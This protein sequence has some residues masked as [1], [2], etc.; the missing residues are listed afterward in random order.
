MLL[1]MPFFSRNR[2]QSAWWL[3]GTLYVWWLSGCAGDP[4]APSTSVV[5]SAMPEESGFERGIVVS[6]AQVW[7]ETGIVLQPGQSVTV[8]AT[9]EIVG[10][11]PRRGEPGVQA[12]V[13]P[14]GT[15]LFSDD[16][17]DREFPLPAA[18][19]GPAPCYGLIARIGDGP[20]FFVGRAHSWIADRGGPLQLGINDFDVSDN[21]GH[22]L[23]NV[24]LTARQHPVLYERVV[25]GREPPGRPAE[26]CSV[27]VFYVDGL[28]PDVVR[29]MAALGHLPNIRRHFLDNGAWL[30]K[31]FTAFPSDTITSNGTM[32]TGCF[33]DR[34]GIKGQVNF[35]RRRL[36]SESFLDPFGPQRSASWLS[37]Q[38][39]DKV[40]QQTQAAAV[41]LVQGAPGREEWLEVRQSSVP[42]LYE[43]LQNAGENW[44]VGVLPVMT[45]VPPPLWSRS[46]TRQMPYFQT[47]RA[48]EY[49]DDANADYAVKNLL[50]RREKVTIVW[51]SETDTCSHKC[52]RGQFGVTRRTIARADGLIGGVVDEL[53]AQGRLDNTYLI[54]VSDHGHVGGRDTHLSH[55]DLASD[56]FFRP[57]QINADGEWVGGGLGLS[58]RMHRYQNRHPDDSS[59]EFVF[60]DGDSDGVARIFL[61]KGRYRSQDWSAPNRPG[62]LLHYHLDHGREAVDLPRSIASIHAVHGN[63][64]MTMPIDLVLMTL[65]ES[66]VLITTADRGQA[67]VERRPGAR[68]RWEYRYFVVERVRPAPDGNVLW[69]EVA[70][71]LTDPLRLSERHSPAF[72][73]AWHDE[74][75][76]LELTADTE[77]PDAVVALTRHLLW[78]EELRGCEKEYGSDLVVTARAGWYFGTS[79]SPGTMHGYPLRE[80]ARATWFVS[81][82]NVRRGARV[83]TPARLADLT[84]TILDMVGLWDTAA[85]TPATFDGRPMRELYSPGAEYLASSQPVYWE[86]VDLRAWQPLTYRE[87][88]RSELLPRTIHHPEKPLDLNNLAY[89]LATIPEL[90][91]FRIMD[92]VIS[93]LSGGARPITTLVERTDA[94]FRRQPQAVLAQGARVPDVPNV[95]LADYSV[96]SQG[97]LQRVDRAIDWMQDCG[98]LVD[99]QLAT[100]F[101]R[102]SLP[103]TGAVNWTVDAAQYTFWET[104]RFGQRVVIKLV[105]ET[106]LNTVEAGA[107]RALNGFR[108]IPNEVTTSDP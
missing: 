108:R 26:N 29:E 46:L 90:S 86:E 9:G 97:N 91:I 57:R 87:L 98:E 75:T 35:N 27:V 101:R 55:F 69:D 33:S 51:L 96:T 38:G 107:D 48:W 43:I 70:A 12:Q 18:G 77:Y 16:A 20:P 66:S 13:G 42:P 99:Q 25:D 30:E 78:D 95:A 8:T 84:P 62:D 7:T 100:P 50:G 63:G 1:R 67:V 74:R 61:P 36:D 17:A 104:Y 52:S 24:D 59:K 81:G 54:L 80:A 85:A 72:M 64:Q 4:A 22:F 76:W 3:A 23:A 14:E 32:W 37:P 6:A 11:E 41:G 83:T 58:V 39:V 106:V 44:A 10:C 31:T 49:I 34:H 53:E 47:H 2:R 92:D 60:I 79:G 68:S 21:A 40:V 71:P 73:A 28:R 94:F 45:E 65:T 88:S 89:G 19:G 93:P 105:D 82:P 5:R 103:L 15:F 56:F 102:Q